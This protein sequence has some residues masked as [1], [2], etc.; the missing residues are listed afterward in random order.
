MDVFTIIQLKGL[1]LKEVNYLP[2]YR[3][4]VKQSF[5]HVKVRI[6]L[7][8]KYDTVG[9]IGLSGVYAQYDCD[10]W[11]T[12]ALLFCPPKVRSVLSP[13]SCFFGFVPIHFSGSLG[14]LQWTCTQ[15]HTCTCAVKP[16]RGAHC[17][18]ELKRLCFFVLHF[19][20]RSVS[21]G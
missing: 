14:L 7:H 12:V 15:T 5:A 9:F 11:H 16:L 8:I 17:I 13:V 20:L 19:H 3:R 2:G 6:K 21:V 10:N 1:L 4:F 18:V